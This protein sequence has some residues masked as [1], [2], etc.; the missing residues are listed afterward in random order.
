MPPPC[1]TRRVNRQQATTLVFAAV[2]ASVLG[3]LL[4]VEP[5]SSTFYAL[6]FGLAAVWA[7]GAFAAGPLHLGRVG[8]GLYLRQLFGPAVWT[9]AQGRRPVIIG[10]GGGVVLATVFVLGGLLV[11]ELTFLEPLERAIAQV[12]QFANQGS[13][14]LLLVITVLNGLAEETFFRGAVFDA[15]P[16]RKVVVSTALYVV[17]TALTGNVML[18]FAAIVI[19]AVTGY[20]RLVTGGIL[21]PMLTHITWS[22]TMLYAL[23]AIFVA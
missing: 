12:V 23:P 6:T 18:A 17:A 5:G 4:R 13:A 10:V 16:H 3:F 11:R 21:A 9:W 22:V 8:D 19:G 15:V 20:Q 14:P 2:G 7:V 1:Q